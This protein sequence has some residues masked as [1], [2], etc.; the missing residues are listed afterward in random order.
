[1]KT[2][3]PLSTKTNPTGT[4]ISGVTVLWMTRSPPDSCA[5]LLFTLVAAQGQQ[6]CSRQDRLEDSDHYCLARRGT[7]MT[8]S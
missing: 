3:T 2:K 6:S 7:G 1:M 4:R 5:G 8:T